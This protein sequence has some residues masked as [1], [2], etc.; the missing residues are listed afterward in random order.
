M[1][2]YLRITAQILIVLSIIFVLAKVVLYKQ[3]LRKQQY[4]M[5]LERNNDTF[6][7]EHSEVL[8]RL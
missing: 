3:A 6:V 1:H 2:K 5:Y 4:I 7:P 8:D